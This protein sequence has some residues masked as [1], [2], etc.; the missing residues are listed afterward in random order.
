MPACLDL[1]GPG[2]LKKAV[3]LARDMRAAQRGCRGRF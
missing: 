2:F 3:P 1:A